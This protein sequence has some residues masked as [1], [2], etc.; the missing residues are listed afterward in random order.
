M[1]DPAISLLLTLGG[2]LLFATAALHKL[3][4]REAFTA[5]LR[6][7]RLLPGALVPA[8]ALALVF[9]EF[10]VAGG[11]L[12]SALR[13]VVLWPVVGAIALL[14]LYAAAISINLVRGR[15]ELDC[16]CSFNRK[17]I[18]GGMVARNGVLAGLL[19]LSL[20]QASGRALGVMDIVL[21]GAA[22][23]AAVLIYQ[24]AELLLG[25]TISVT[26]HS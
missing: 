20:L 14:L 4:S 23:L 12:A 2:A 22:L 1:L 25:Q 8:A 19:G 11:L 10:F 9:T 16:G 3:R 26:E 13:G 24:A 17:A 15:R 5:T 6:D 7:Y 18:G 21:I